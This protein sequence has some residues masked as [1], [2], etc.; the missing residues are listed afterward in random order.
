VSEPPP[1]PPPPFFLKK[2]LLSIYI[3][4][5]LYVKIYSN[6]TFFKFT[7]YLLDYKLTNMLL[8]I[9]NYNY[10]LY[11][12]YTFYVYYTSPTQLNDECKLQCLFLI[13]T[14]RKDKRKINIK[15]EIN[16][17][18][19]NFKWLPVVPTYSLVGIKPTVV[20]FS[21]RF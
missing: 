21:F 10:T 9:I 3:Y 5:T 18:C 2:I 12:L 8:I 19:A 15:I 20:H 17:F 1:P 6:Y 4:Y 16:K 11:I 13:L 7:C 14:K